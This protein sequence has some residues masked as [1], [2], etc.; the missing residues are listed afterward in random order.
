[1]L[2]S[3]Y[4]N[5]FNN[6]SLMQRSIYELMFKKGWYCIDEAP[7]S[8]ITEKLTMLSQKYEDLELKKE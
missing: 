1:M 2:T 6:I 7:Q 4:I 3:R 5:M 8:K